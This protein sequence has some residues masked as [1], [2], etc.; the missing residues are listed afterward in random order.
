[1]AEA[2]WRDVNRFVLRGRLGRD[3]EA[4]PAGSGKVVKF[5][6]ATGRKWTGQDGKER[7]DTVWVD[8]VVWAEGLQPLAETLKKGTRVNVVGTAKLRSWTGQ[9]GKERTSLECVVNQR[10]GELSV[11]PDDRAPRANT[12]VQP[13]AVAARSDL[14]DEIPF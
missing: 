13:V 3:A 2:E 7:D 1:M 11:V 8:V 4:R 9:D 12:P 10:D 6:L 14:D 5:S